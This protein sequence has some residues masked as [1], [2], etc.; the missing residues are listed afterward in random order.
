MP[1]L[2]EMRILAKAG[3]VV[4]TE[5]WTSTRYDDGGVNTIDARYSY[6][7]ST[8]LDHITAGGRAT[9]PIRYV[10]SGESSAKTAT[11]PTTTT[12]S[13]STT[14]TT[15][16]IPKPT[17]TTLP[18]ASGG[19]CKP[20][21]VGPGGGIVFYDA[22]KVQPWG[23]FLEAAPRDYNTVSSY[24]KVARTTGTDWCNGWGNMAGTTGDGIGAGKANTAAMA[25]AC[26][27][28][29]GKFADDYVNGKSTDWYLPSK[30]ELNELLKRKDI[31]GDANSKVTGFT[32]YSGACYWSSTQ[33]NDK[34]AVFNAWM[35]W[36]DLTQ[37][38]YVKSQSCFARFIRSF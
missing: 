28:G 4:G 7:G 12:T 17:T 30:A 35:Q 16:T 8:G 31:F 24:D 25:K 9:A 34:Y 19:A 23:R 29:A 10:R 37:W 13:T 14:S 33:L 15:T 36:P 2:E 38:S 3:R 18:C 11:P 5:F 21:D 22:G 20:G 27:T 1:S 32:S 26:T 6:R